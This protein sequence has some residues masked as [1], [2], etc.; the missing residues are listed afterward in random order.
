[1]YKRRLK[2]VTALLALVMVLLSQSVVF[3]QNDAGSGKGYAVEVYA[4]E[5]NLKLSLGDLKGLP[6]EY[7]ID[8]EYI[9]NSK[10][11]VKSAKVKGVSLAHLLKEKAGINAGVTELIFKASDGYPIDPQP[12]EDV[13]S[14]DLKYVLA[15]EVNGE[16]IDNDGDPG[17]EEIVVYR[18]VKEEGEFGTVFKLVDTITVDEEKL[19]EKPKEEPVEKP[20]DSV[21]FTDVTAEYEF[22]KTAIKKLAELGIINGMG[23]NKYAPGQEFTRAQ[24]C[25]IMVEV[26]NYELVEYEG[27]FTDVKAGDWFVSY[28]GT[29]VKTGLFQGYPDKTFG[30]DKN[31]TRQELATAVG[32]AAI[33]AELVGEEKMAKFIM[34]KTPFEDKA[35]VAEWAAKEVAWLEAQ[36]AF[37]GVADKNFE[38]VKVV[39]RAEAAVIVYNTFFKE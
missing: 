7:Q 5:E 13:L 39:N 33:Q 12:L 26:L 27:N 18:K 1:M 19:V 2:V 16:A 36:G 24:F 31:I 10:G 3:A 15:Y 17:N 38:P 37:K 11:G 21:E 29:A 8:D 32:R 4:G 23:D 28:V 30:P 22:A 20:T 34:D 14:E 25:K 35:S 9:Y 6:A